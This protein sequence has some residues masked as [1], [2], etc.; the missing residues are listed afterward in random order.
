MFKAQTE[1]VCPETFP[2]LKRHKH[3]AIDLETRDPNLKSKGSGALV[4]EGDRKSV[5]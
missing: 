3:I 5:V 2:D 1:W 4:N